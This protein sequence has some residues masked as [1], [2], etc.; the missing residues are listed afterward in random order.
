MNVLRTEGVHEAIILDEYGGFTG[1][2]TLHDIMEEIV[3]LMP[4]GEEE[5]KEE[6]NKIIERDGAWLVDGLSQRR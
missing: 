3:G 6:E 5:I 2:V 1:L 4:S